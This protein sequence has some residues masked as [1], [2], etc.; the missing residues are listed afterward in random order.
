MNSKK[1]NRKMPA[2]NQLMDARRLFPFL[3]LIDWKEKERLTAA[4]S[5]ILWIIDTAHYEWIPATHVVTL[6][7]G[8][9][10]DEPTWRCHQNPFIGALGTLCLAVDL[11]IKPLG[12]LEVTCVLAV[13][14]RLWF[15]ST[16]STFQLIPMATQRLSPA[17]A[18]ITWFARITTSRILVH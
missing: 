3:E 9:I 7:D 8:L 10:H 1:W 2:H 18:S 5:E 16:R 11:S 17:V 14:K 4:V 12:M 13:N 15:A 6:I